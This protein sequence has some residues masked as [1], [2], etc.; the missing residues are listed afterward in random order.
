MAVR[1]RHPPSTLKNRS[2]IVSTINVRVT[3]NFTPNDYGC[4]VKEI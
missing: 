3:R 4:I 1:I 2:F